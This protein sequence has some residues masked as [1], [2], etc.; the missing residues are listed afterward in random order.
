MGASLNPS[1]YSNICINDLVLYNY[2]VVA[3][4]LRAGEV[5]GIQI[6]TGFPPFEGVHTITL[7]LGPQNQPQYYTYILGL[8]P[9]R[10]IFNPGTWNPD[11]A[12]MAAE[13]GIE[14]ESKCTLLML[15]GGYY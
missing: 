5:A 1:R 9:Q 2:P 12:K 15:S 14:V 11:L 8:H 6:E 3:V 7:Y 4:G 13:Q 10:V